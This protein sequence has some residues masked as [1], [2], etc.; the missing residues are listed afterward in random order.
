MYN[1]RDFEIELFGKAVKDREIERKQ[2]RE[3]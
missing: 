2:E 1:W 3:K